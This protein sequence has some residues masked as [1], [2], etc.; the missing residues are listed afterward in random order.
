[1][2]LGLRM[3]CVVAMLVTLAGCAGGPGVRGDAPMELSTASDVSPERRYAALRI[4][5]ASGYYQQGSDSVALDEIKKALAVVPDYGPAFNLRGLIYQRLNEPR[6]AESSVRRALE[7]NPRDG[8]AWHNLGWLLCQ[9]D[10][11]AEG[12]DAIA[13]ALAVPNY[14]GVGRS[15]MVQGVCQVRAKQPAQA[16]QTLL[17]AFEVEPAN[18]TVQFELAKLLFAR[19]ES[20]K[21]RFYIRRVNNSQYGNAETLWLGIRIEHRLGGG[22]AEAQLGDQLRRRYPTSP[23]RQKYDRRTF[24]E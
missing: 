15:L 19:G 24:D 16:E 6:L 5:L 18:P 10:R 23:E 12:N 13:R 9:Q 21:A 7:I 3:G 1:M 17:R 20:E 14:A 2:K 11:F 22:E 8:D 4:E